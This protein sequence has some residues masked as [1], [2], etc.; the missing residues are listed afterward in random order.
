MGLATHASHMHVASLRQA[1]TSNQ[2]ILDL[3][4]TYYSYKQPSISCAIIDVAAINLATAYHEM[5]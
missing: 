4:R 1:A 2:S 3:N 5:N